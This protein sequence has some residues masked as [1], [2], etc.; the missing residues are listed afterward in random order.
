LIAPRP[1]GETT[2]QKWR[3]IGRITGSCR[4]PER[5]AF[6][7]YRTAILH[8]SF[9]A[10]I[11]YKITLK[12]FYIRRRF[13]DWN[14]VGK[15]FERVRSVAAQSVKCL[16]SG[17]W[18]AL[19][20]P[21]VQPWRHFDN[22]SSKWSSGD[23]SINLSALFVEA[24]H[25]A[26]TIWLKPRFYLQNDERTG[27]SIVFPFFFPRPPFDLFSCA[28]VSLIYWVLDIHQSQPNGD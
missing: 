28:M 19:T 8:K 27:F 11:T 2:N 4:K 3:S 22:V 18:I 14:F 7:Y 21:S 25:H 26:S 16:Y 15:A 12:Y 24:R 9:F 17:L 20:R 23:T 13:A 5:I 10:E 1:F 6:W